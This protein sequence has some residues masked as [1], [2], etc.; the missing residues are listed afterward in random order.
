ME[1][2]SRKTFPRV[3]DG[4]GKAVQVTAWDVS[5]HFSQARLKVLTRFLQTG[6]SSDCLNLAA[7]LAPRRA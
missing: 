3:R 2:Q 6:G 5:G 4:M 1:G 7:D